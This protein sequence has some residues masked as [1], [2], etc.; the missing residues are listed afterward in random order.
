MID[1]K[2]DISVDGIKLDTLNREFMIALD[3]AL[4]TNQSMYLTGKAG[5]GKT[6]FLKYLRSVS[7]K[8][9]VVLAPT[10]VAAINAGGQTIHSFFQ[11]PP[12]LYVPGDVRLRTHVPV[13]STDKSTV[14]DNF[15]YRS[16]KVNLIRNLEM[17]VIDEVSM[18]RSDLLDVVDTLLRVYRK[19]QNPFGGVQVILIGDTFQL[20]PVVKGPEKDVLSRFY[21]SEFFFSAKVMKRMEPVYIELKKIYRQSEQEFIDLLNRVRVNQATAKDYM[22]FQS[23]LNPSFRPTS[24]D[25]YII[26]APTNIKVDWV[27]EQKLQ[28]LKTTEVSYKAV[29][30]GEFPLNTRPAESDLRLKV[31]AQ[32]I[33]LK[34]DREKR[35]YNGKIGVVTDLREEE[36]EVEIDDCGEKRK[37]SVSKETWMNI[38]YRWDEKAQRV[39]EEVL[40]TFTQYPLKLAWAITVHKSQGLTFEKVVADLGDSFASGQVYVALSRCTSLDGLVLTSNITPRSIKTDRRVLEFA[41]KETPETLLTEKLDEGKADYYYGEARKA[42]AERD[43]KKTMDNLYMAIQYRNDVATESFRR[44]VSLWMSKFFLRE[45][46]G[47]QYK[48]QVE[49]ISLKSKRVVDENTRLKEELLEKTNRLSGTD[50][51]IESYE[52]ELA[53]LKKELSDAKRKI[54][55]LNKQVDRLDDSLS[56]KKKTESSLRAAQTNLIKQIRARDNEIA[57][58]SSIT[59][60]QKLFGKK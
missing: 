3:Y 32:V 58:L 27:N 4:H 24:N 16:D 57:R 28:E 50:A 49:E 22:T 48:Q 52:S 11:I 2:V 6:T 31:G 20:P 53:A 33:F 38:L 34:N 14:Y 35:F 42:L 54:A 26:L 47:I 8:N 41:E 51:Q 43:V 15:R 36:V 45:Q 39:V 59:W 25:Q 7:Q 9:M 44:F 12:S 5:S 29:V 30:R 13:G 21:E 10:G 23:K 37:L 18:V 55:S 17:I 1:E 60:Y 40:G 46:M 56:T 19:D